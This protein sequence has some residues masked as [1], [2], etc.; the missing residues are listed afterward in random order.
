MERC[1]NVSNNPYYPGGP[2]LAGVTF[3]SYKMFCGNKLPPGASYPDRRTRE[4][5]NCLT[6][7]YFYLEVGPISEWI[8]WVESAKKARSRTRRIEWGC[9]S[10]RVA[11]TF[12]KAGRAHDLR[13]WHLADMVID[14]EH[15]RS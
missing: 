12:G 8:C 2:P 5:A 1:L 3:A 4:S 13:Y 6:R 14:A 15:V 10:R 11:Y 9:S 7:G